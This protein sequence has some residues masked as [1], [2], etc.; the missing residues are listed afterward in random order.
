MCF[1]FPKQQQQWNCSSIKKISGVDHST[2]AKQDGGNCTMFLVKLFCVIL[3]LVFSQTNGHEL[4]VAKKDYSANFT[5]LDVRDAQNCVKACNQVRKCGAFALVDQGDSVDCFIEDH[6][7]DVRLIDVPIMVKSCE[8]KCKVDCPKGFTKLG[9]VGGCYR[10]V[11]K[12]RLQWMEAQAS[13]QKSVRHCKAHLIRINN[14]KVHTCTIW[15][16]VR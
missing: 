2:I 9:L 13:C 15:A 8:N 7:G 4:Y 12:R 6:Y 14:I 10:P 3:F 1:L 16:I 5:N 11:I